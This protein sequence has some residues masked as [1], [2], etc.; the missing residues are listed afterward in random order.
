MRSAWT[1]TTVGDIAVADGISG[2][3]FGSDLVRADYVP[4][5][6]PVIRGGN[7]S[8]GEHRFRAT[9]LV[10]VSDAKA[11]SLT[12]PGAALYETGAWARSL[13]CLLCGDDSLGGQAHDLAPAL[14]FASLDGTRNPL[15]VVVELFRDG[16]AGR[17]NL[18]DDRIGLSHGVIP[19]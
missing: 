1:Q 3:P 5:G 7:L 10:F 8:I 4:A 11:D 18:V 12:R 19:P 17:A 15:D 9:D 13:R 2:G 6:V 16:V 14:G